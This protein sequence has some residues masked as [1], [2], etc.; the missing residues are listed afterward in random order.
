MHLHIIIPVLPHAIRALFAICIVATRFCHPR[1]SSTTGIFCKSFLPTMTVADN[2][3]YGQVRWRTMFMM[4]IAVFI[5][6][7]LQTLGVALDARGKQKRATTKRVVYNGVL[8][9]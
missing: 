2:D 5:F 6:S 8:P 4:K 3:G 7:F 9:L 1:I